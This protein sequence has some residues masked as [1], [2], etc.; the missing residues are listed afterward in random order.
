MDLARLVEE[1]L[2]SSGNPRAEARFRHCLGVAKQMVEL[3]TFHKLPLDHELVFNTGLV[4]DYAKY[5]T[6]AEW[7]ELAKTYPAILKDLEAPATLH[8]ALCG[9][10]LIDRELGITDPALLEAVKYH[11]T[12]KPRMSLLNELLFISDYIEGSRHGTS[13]DQARALA[14]NHL[15]T[16][17]FAILIYKIEYI[18]RRGYE[19]YPLT[20]EAYHAYSSSAIHQLIDEL[21]ISI[22]I[23]E[24]ITK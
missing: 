19:V 12:G 17:C 5:T 7:I 4:H 15:P 16:A 21:S 8:H 2:L 6:K 14:I 18:L 24:K 9:P 23:D 10:Y 1:K 22:S 11:A 13:F 20:L 3:A